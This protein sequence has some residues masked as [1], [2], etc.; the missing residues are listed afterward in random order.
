MIESFNKIIYNIC[1]HTLLTIPTYN[2]IFIL[3]CD[4][5]SYGVDS[6]L[7]VVRGD[8]ELPVAFYTRQLLPLETRYSAT[9]LEVLALLCSVKHFSFYLFG[10]SF[11]VTT[12]H[13]EH[14]FDSFTLNNNLWRWLMP[15]QEYDYNIVITLE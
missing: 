1:D 11:R 15:L 12:D 2:N 3:S 10:K 13:I 7:S 9:E 4:T 14:H 8:L 6:V 5:S